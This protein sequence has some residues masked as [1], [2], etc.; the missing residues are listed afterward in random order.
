MELN[1][2]VAVAMAFGP[3]AGLELVDAL[4]S[5]PSLE[6]YHLLPS[7]RGDL[8]AKLGRFDEARAEFER[9]A[10]LTR[11]ARERELLLAARGGVRRSD[12]RR[13]ARRMIVHLVDGTYELFRHFYGLRRFN[14]GEDRPFGAVAG[15]LHTVLQMIETGA[16]HVGVATDHVIES[17]RND[18]WPGYKT[19]DGIEPAL[20]WRSSIRSRTR[21]PR[22]ASPS[23][24]WSSSRPTTRSPPRRSIAAAD[25]RGRAGLHLDAGQGP[26][27]VRA[28]R[29]RRAGRPAGAGRSATPRAC[30]RSSAS[31]PRCIP[32]FLALVGDAADGYPGHRRASGRSTR[33]AARSTGTAASRTSRRRS[34]AS[35]ASSRCCSRTSRRCAPTR[36]CSQR[37]R[38][39][40]ARPDPRVRAPGGELGDPRSSERALGV[41]GKRDGRRSPESRLG[42]R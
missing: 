32:D 3:A 5:E 24:R 22:W 16:T 25:E 15:V 19:G 17:F 34:S 1:R 14:K 13:G 42:A 26:R 28:R 21:S 40:L 9:A 2:A 36:R 8:L 38:A 6:G 29:P 41:P 12:C 35:A 30:A 18:L 11:N 33:G 20:C 31:S 4:T 7:V 10:S 39:A 37:R 27:A 23:G